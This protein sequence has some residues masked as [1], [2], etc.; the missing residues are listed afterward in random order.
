MT[1]VTNTDF[2]SFSQAVNYAQTHSFAVFPT[3]GI[4]SLTGMDGKAYLACTCGNLACSSPG[5]HPAIGKGLKAASKDP[6]VIENLWAGRQGL[7]LAIATGV[8]SGIFVVDV[9]GEAGERSL[10]DLPELPKTLTCRT[11]RGHHYYF[12]YPEKKVY[13]RTHVWRNIDIR[14][15]GGYVIGADSRHIEGVS[16]Q[17]LDE[18][19]PIAEAPDWLL[20]AVCAEKKAPVVHDDLLTNASSR[21]WEADDVRDMLTYID[22]SCGYDEWVNIGMALH[23]GGFHMAL[24]DDWSKSSPKYANNCTYHWRSFKPGGGITMGT[25]V[26][27]AKL[28]GWKP[29]EYI[30]EPIDWATHPARDWAIS[31]G[32]YK[33][34]QTRSGKPVEIA[35]PVPAAS[36]PTPLKLNAREIP[37]I[38]G[39]T[40][41]WICGTAVFEQPEMAMLNVFCALGA[42]FGRRYASTT[43][44][45][46]NLYCCSISDSTS[47]KDHSRKMVDK[48]MSAAGLDTF[49]A[50][51]AIHSGSGLITQLERQPSHIMMIDEFGLVLGNITSKNAQSHQQDISPKLLDLFTSSDRDWRGGTYADKKVEP[52][53]IHQPNLCIYGTTTLTTYLDALKKIAISS[54]MMNRFLVLPGRT[55]P[56]PRFDDKPRNIPDDLLEKWRALAPTG[57]GEFN[58]NIINVT[59]RIVEWG[60]QCKAY[61]DE[62]L[63]KQISYMR[64]KNAGIE[65][66]FGRYREM[67]TKLAM[68]LAICRDTENPRISID[69]FGTAENVVRT[70]INYV[71]DLASEFMYEN[72]QEKRKRDVTN[73]IRAYG[74]NGVSK[75][76]LL[77]KTGNLK[78]RELEEIMK[79]LL[80]EDKIRAEKVG[81]KVHY[82][83]MGK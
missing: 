69:D 2:D 72:D 81:I 74:T 58:K 10:S 24:W 75:S 53:V 20:D 12:K 52:T 29:K 78:A 77:S 67:T 11:A 39:E 61:Y 71:K 37:G 36:F 13:N 27:R 48:L 8:I 45:R 49:L 54:G 15:E 59:P 18:S 65:I 7:N 42:V 82:F 64:E 73:I 9:D 57:I 41:E 21:E 1:T 33:E 17:W 19:A 28:G 23:E 22:S 34:P 68:I 40:V 14:G 79:G 32:I 43:D 4:K 63:V 80:E 6:A 60:D 50:G 70:S 55:E 66:L 25:L 38:V 35:A 51:G 76:T 5:K 62:L 31:M 83:Y 26:D 47:G 16:Y 56:D 3:Y 46:T 30:S 44:I